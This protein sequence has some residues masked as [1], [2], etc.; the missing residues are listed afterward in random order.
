MTRQREVKEKV[1]GPISRCVAGVWFSWFIRFVWFR[2]RNKRDKPDRPKKLVSLPL[3]RPSPHTTLSQDRSRRSIHNTIRD[4]ADPYK[5]KYP[6]F[7]YSTKKIMS[8]RG[9]VSNLFGRHLCPVTPGF[10]KSNGNGLLSAVDALAAP[11]TL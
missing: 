3:N 11:P 2:E 4:Q 9:L 7:F 10:R 8:Q 1:P 5:I 6:S